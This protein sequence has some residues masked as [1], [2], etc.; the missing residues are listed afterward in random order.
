MSRVVSLR[1]RGVLTFEQLHIFPPWATR[2]F[3]S[4]LLNS[5]SRPWGNQSKY[6]RISRNVAHGCRVFTCSPVND[7]RFPN[8]A[9]PVACCGSP[10]QTGSGATFRFLLGHY[11]LFWVT[12]QRVF[13]PR[14]PEEPI[15]PVGARRRHVPA[16]VNRW[17]NQT[18]WS[19]RQVTTRQ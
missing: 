17:L 11:S 5:N 4:I 18:S 14:H 9:K 6:I 2:R 3:V 15:K 16:R 10:Q 8:H 1:L 19:L 7:T 13:P 12:S